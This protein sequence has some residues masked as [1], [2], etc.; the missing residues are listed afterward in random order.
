MGEHNL[1]NDDLQFTPDIKALLRES[2]KWGKFLSVVGLV[3]SGMIVVMAF[4]LPS[5]ID[6]FSTAQNTEVLPA[7]S[8]AGITINFLIIGAI[9][10]FPCLFLLRFSNAM[11]RALEEINQDECTV[12]FS[13]L[14]TLLKFYG[15]ITLIILGLYAL[16]IILYLIAISFSR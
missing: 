12:A 11:K 5:M 15:I 3:L 1:L 6:T 2:A 8:K 10:F 9:V 7:G 13:N 14:K 4:F 16:A